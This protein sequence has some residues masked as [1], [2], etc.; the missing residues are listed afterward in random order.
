MSIPLL[1]TKFYIPPAQAEF[2]SRPRLV[3]KLLNGVHRPGSFILLAG[4]AGSGKTTLLSAFAARSQ[5]PIAWLSLEKDDNDPVRFWTYLIAACQSVFADV[6]ETALELLGTQ[7]PLPADTVPTLLINDLIK[8]DGSIVLVLDDYHEIQTPSIHAS[9]L[10]LLDHLPENLHII[11]STRTDPPWP[12][13]RYRAR[14]RLVEIRAQDLRFS[15]DEAAE[16]LKRTM[17]LDLSAEDVVAL[18]SRTEGWVAGLQLAAIAL[19]S[20]LAHPTSLPSQSFAALQDRS[21]ISDFIKSFTGSHVYIAEYLVEEVLQSQ[22]VEVRKFLLQ[23]S[24]L[25]RMNAGLGEAVTDCRDGR[26]MLKSLRR[27]NIFVIPLDNEGNWFRYHH[28]FADLLQAHLRQNMAAEELQAL[29]RRASLW[30]EHNSFALEAV[31]HALAAKDFERVADLVERS[32]R[33][34]IFSGRLDILREW[35]EALP[36]DAIR[37]HP[38]LIFYLLWTDILQNRIN[39]SD[40]A[41][42]EKQDLLEAL[43]ST[44]ENDRLSGELMAVICRAVALSGRTSRGIHLAQKALNYLPLDD[45]ASRARANSALATAHDLEGRVEQGEPAYRES[46]FQAIAAGDYRLAAHTMMVRGLVQRHYGQLHEASR[47]FQEI[48]DLG[49]HADVTDMDKAGSVPVKS[50]GSGK[51]FFPAGQG[52]IGLASIHLEWNELETAEHHLKLGMEL[53][54]QAGL[55]GIFIGRMQMS[56][57]HQAKGDLD[58]AVAELQLAEQDFQRVDDFNLTARQIQICLA[59]GDVDQAWHWAAPFAQVLAGAPAMVQIPL[60]FFELIEAMIARVYLAR[61]EFEKTLGLLERLEATA[62]PGNHLAR[63]IE[64]HLLRA[65][66]YQKQNGGS[67]SSKA[68]ESME[69]ALDLGEPEGYVLLF[70]E[71]GPVVIPLLNAVLERQAAPGR[72]RKYVRKLLEA[73][74]EMDSLAV[75]QT[76]SEGGDLVEPLTPREMEVL[77]LLALGDSNQTIADKLFITVRTVKKHTSNIYGKLNVNNRTQAVARASELGLLPED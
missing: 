58:K 30:Y 35:L 50:T 51:V 20:S 43:P 24:I 63:L 25:G 73:F 18:E 4:P 2:V 72:V 65:L 3:D 42:Q 28:L 34:L 6:G 69:Y 62:G 21:T 60:L 61:G 31:N 19:Q 37:A 27:A 46:L 36:E 13:A 32:A 33:T 49:A 67:L 12:L 8:Q 41:V 44:P 5:L 15:F 23:T 77:G 38:H 74:G 45:L 26:A 17:R 64:V 54:R 1:A 9:L 40:Q 70:L 53:C 10:F 59:K 52:Y 11:V 56:R 66:A 57:L 71:S 29:H 7:Q 14:N 47:T 75:S 68:I 76:T 16:F 39:L 22:P 48:I 55:D